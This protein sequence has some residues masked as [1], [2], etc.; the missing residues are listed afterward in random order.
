[1]SVALVGVYLVKDIEDIYMAIIVA[2]I[3]AVGIACQT[4]TDVKGKKA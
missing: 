2:S 3:I 1:M 4:Y